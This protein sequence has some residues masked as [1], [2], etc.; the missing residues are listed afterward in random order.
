MMCK[1]TRPQREEVIE[2]KS[3][4]YIHRFGSYHGTT[5]DGENA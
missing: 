3:N 2:K 5:D 1:M 4:M